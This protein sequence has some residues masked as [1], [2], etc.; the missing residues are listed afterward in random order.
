MPSEPK[1]PVPEH[2]Y[3]SASSSAQRAPTERGHM[4]LFSL[5]PISVVHGASEFRLPPSDK[6]V[7]D[8]RTSLDFIMPDQI[9]ESSLQRWLGEGRT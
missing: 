3:V 9:I 2:V 1:P 5:I 6:D 4:R 8:R 7:L